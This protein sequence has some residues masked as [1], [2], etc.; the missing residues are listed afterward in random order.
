MSRIMKIMAVVALFAM[1]VP[2]FAAV[3]NIKVGGDI[4][5][6]GVLRDG[7]SPS[8]PEDNN[9]IQ[10][11]TRIYV[12]ASLTENV[13]AMVRFINERG[14]G[15]HTTGSGCSGISEKSGSEMDIDLDLAYIK[16][17]DLMA[18]GLALTVGR[19]EI[20]FGEGLVVGSAYSTDY[21]GAGNNFAGD[22]GLKKAFDA[23]RVDYTAAGAPVDITAFV[24]TI[25]EDGT[26]DYDDRLYGLN[27]GFDAADV[28]RVEG[29]YVRYENLNKKGTSDFSGDITTVGIRATGDV[30][31]FGLKGEFAKQLGTCEDVGYD[32]DNEGWALLLGGSYNL[33]TEMDANVHANFN[34][35]TGQDSSLDNTAWTT[36]FPSNVASRIGA[37]NYVLAT[38][39][40]NRLTNAQ[41]INIGG[42]IRPVEKIGLSLDWFNVNL[43]EDETWALGKDDIGNEI[44]A[45]IVYDYTEDLS[46]GLQYGILL[47]GDALDNTSAGYDDDPWQLIASMKLAF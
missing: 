43:R 20:Q 15:T 14:W 39:S 33:P 16:V 25:S 9:F 22:L 37:I 42:G 47:C 28:A 30:A 11:S 21:P 26:N 27:V 29:Y 18:P 2:A 17:S 4:E 31:G 36:F 13:E 34:L 19:Q 44:D 1:A 45:A 23:I 7:F 5:I 6:S 35:Y 24:A 41:V 40:G 3:E 8:S 12:H 10:T 32:K 46:F 38:M